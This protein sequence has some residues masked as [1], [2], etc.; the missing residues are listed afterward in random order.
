MN[1]VTGVLMA[2]GVALTGSDG[3]GFP[4]VNLIG[5][6]CL[7]IAVVRTPQTTRTERGRGDHGVYRVI[8]MIVRGGLRHGQH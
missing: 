4:H 1:R 6:V 3:P 5:L 7:C 2:A 8:Q